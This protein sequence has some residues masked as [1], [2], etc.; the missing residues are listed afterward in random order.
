MGKPCDLKLT[1][2]AVTAIN[3]ILARGKSVEIAVRKNKI[4]I[5][6]VSSKTRYEV[7]VEV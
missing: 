7:I 2:E 4:I 3:E 5:W 6:E 1:N